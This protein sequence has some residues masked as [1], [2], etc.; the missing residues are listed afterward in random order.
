MSNSS[1]VHIGI[2]VSKA[3]LDC[4]LPQRCLQLPNSP[5]GFQKLLLL[6]PAN[7]HVCMEATG[8]YERPLAEALHRSSIPL[9]VLN[10]GHVRH[11]A[12]SRG[13]LAK[14]DK[15]DAK[16]LADYGRSHNPKPSPPPSPC[17]RALA[18][19]NSLR[20]KLVDN[21]TQI[22]NACEHLALPAA[23]SILKAELLHLRKQ[24][25]KIEKLCQKVLNADPALATRDQTLRAIPGIGPVTSCTLIAL[26]PELGH[27]G[28]GTIA[29]LAGLAPICDD[30]GPRRG[31]RHIRGGRTRV[32]RAL[33][34]ATLSAIRSGGFL[35]PL[36]TRLRTKGK[37]V[38][39][40]LIACARRLLIHINLHL[41][42]AAA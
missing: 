20:D 13:I 2:D 19:L 41:K 23:K 1:L 30:S 8:G 26:L 7:V 25:Q 32:R 38:K 3:H 14:T 12:L 29:A 9:S 40:A 42:T 15:I 5:Q 10:P 21:Q 39:V 34:M 4:A 6:L 37:P 11:F 31:Q 18:E 24:I 22:I 36:Y 33:Y 28:R 16:V 27:V 17:Q 35:R